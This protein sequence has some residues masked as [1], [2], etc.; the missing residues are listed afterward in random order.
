MIHPYYQ[1]N[2][3]TL[4]HGKQEDILPLL[5][6]RADCVLTDPPYGL[7]DLD[8]DVV[9][10]LAL[11]WQNMRRVSKPS[12]VMAL[13]CQQPFTTDL[14]VSNRKAWRYE[15]IW[16]KNRGTGFLWSKRKPLKAHEHIQ[17]FIDEFNNSVYNPQ[18]RK[19]EPYKKIQ[20][21][22]PITHYHGVEKC[23]DVNNESGDRHPIST[24]FYNNA[25]GNKSF[26]STGKPIDLLEYIILTYTNTDN[27][28][29]DPFIGSGSTAVAAAK[30]GRRCIGIEMREEAL[31]VA[32]KRLSQQP[33]A[34]LNY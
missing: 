2:L 10:D 14:I 20:K 27:L 5:D 28:I 32:V 4:Y 3:V 13:F 21:N 16:N 22:S 11:M 9:P 7:T 30:I 34:M 26:H 15:W 18:M 6:I 23:T 12:A 31:E 1:D 24:L 8:W 19:G 25:A 33:L 17:I 29:L